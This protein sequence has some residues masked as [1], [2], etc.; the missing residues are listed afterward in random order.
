MDMNRNF[1][2]S[3][4]PLFETLN[5]LAEYSGSDQ[6]MYAPCTMIFSFLVGN[7]MLPTRPHFSLGGP[8]PLQYTNQHL[9]RR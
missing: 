8:I 9:M 3:F 7:C 1:R 2:S 4:V 6:A 5:I